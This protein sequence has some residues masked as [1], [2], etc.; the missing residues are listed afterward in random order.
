MKKTLRLLIVEDSPDDAALLL[1]HLQRSDYEIVLERVDTAEAMQAALDKAPW[2]AVI[3]DYA[4][5]RFNALEALA[6]LKKSEHDY[7]FIIVSG[8][9]G[10]ETAVEAMR[11]GAHDYLMKG[12]LLRLL[13]T[14]EREMREATVR[15]KR[16]EADLALYQNEEKFRFM[17]EHSPVPMWVMDQNT[18]MFLEVN[19]AAVSHYGYGRQEFLKMKMMDLLVLPET[20]ESSDTP[21]GGHR[22]I[23]E[24][25]HRLKSGEIIEVEMHSN[26][27]ELAGTVVIFAIAQDISHRK[28]TERDL[29]KARETAL[30]T[31]RLKSEFLAN[32]SH[33]IRTPLNGIIGMTEILEET[34]LSEEQ[35]GCTDTIKYSAEALLGIVKQILDFSKTETGR[36]DI[37]WTDFSLT[38]LVRQTAN[39][40]SHSAQKKGIALTTQIA[41]EVPAS[42]RGDPEKIQQI[43]INMVGNAIKFTEKGQVLLRIETRQQE[44]EDLTL[45]FFIEDTGIGIPEHARNRIFQ[46]F[47]QVDSSTTRKYG[48]TG[49]GLA[50]CRQLVEQLGGDIGFDSVVGQGSIFW[51]TIPVKMGIAPSPGTSSASPASDN[52]FQL[53]LAHGSRLLVVEDN[54]INKNVL[55]K[56]LKKLG[57]QADAV[58]NGQLAIDALGRQTYDLVLMDCQMPVMDGYEATTAIRQKETDTGRHIPIIAVTA[59]VMQG[60]REKCLKAGMDDYIPKPVNAGLLKTTLEKW[61]AKIPPELL[62]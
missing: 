50:I 49:L 51:F 23:G 52:A 8:T 41:P 46:A 30:E 17:F 5:P 2:D 18:S 57:Y 13:P 3:C 32:V 42:L 21:S 55:L 34:P 38:D 39:I 59:H 35:K 4:M 6:L 1:R 56:M 25:R 7:P 22:R 54:V 28:Q 44:R 53:S 20:S 24:E 47:S 12:N 61:L 40:L 45:A 11:T 14:I 19:Q 29:I 60:D 62:K 33:E 43:L 26:R 36:G 31:S 16:A 58:D 10:E 27:L 48:G 9:I 37:R 15:E